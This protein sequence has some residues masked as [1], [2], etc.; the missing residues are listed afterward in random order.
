ML[1]IYNHVIISSLIFILA[2]QDYKTMHVTLLPL[3]IFVAYSIFCC[4]DDP[5]IIISACVL[6]GAL[7]YSKLLKD[8]IGFVDFVIIACCTLGLPIEYIGPFLACIG[9]LSVIYIL[10]RKQSGIKKIPLVPFI[11]LAYFIFSILLHIS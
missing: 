10:A 7:Y 1:N 5:W 8:K 3:A 4:I 11:F 6:L 9:G 2:W